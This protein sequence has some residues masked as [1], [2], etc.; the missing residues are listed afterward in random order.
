MTCSSSRRWT[1]DRPLA[2]E[3]VAAEV[4]DAMQA[5][6]AAHGVAV[7]LQAEERLPAVP[8]DGALLERAIRNLVSNALEYTPAGGVVT[9]TVERDGG[10]LA[11][12]VHDTGHGIEADDLPRVWD[13]FF[14]AER[15]RSRSSTTS[16]GAGLG[17]AIV[18][19]IAEAHGGTVRVQSAPGRGAVFTIQV[20]ME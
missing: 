17:L 5:Q 1:R 19:G 18:R 3:E 12:R 13:R 16:D 11:L 9:V 20:P 2:L 6:A 10:W 4:V 8:L 15:S 7:S 14:R